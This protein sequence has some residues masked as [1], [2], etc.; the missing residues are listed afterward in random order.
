MM[1]VSSELGEKALLSVAMMSSQMS[2][3]VVTLDRLK[4]KVKLS[5]SRIHEGVVSQEERWEYDE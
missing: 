2:F 1:A 3:D 4:R 5:V